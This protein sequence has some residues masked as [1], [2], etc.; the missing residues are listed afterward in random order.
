MTI[1]NLCNCIAFAID[2]MDGHI[3]YNLLYFIQRI[4]SNMVMIDDTRIE[5]SYLEYTIIL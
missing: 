1:Q 5:D 2:C 3:S 4:S